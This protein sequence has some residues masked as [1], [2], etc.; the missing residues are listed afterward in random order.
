MIGPRLEV[1][2]VDQ[3]ENFGSTELSN[4][5][6]AHPPGLR[7]TTRY[8]PRS[9]GGRTDSQNFAGM[10]LLGLPIVIFLVCGICFSISQVMAMWSPG[11]A[12]RAHRISKVLAGLWLIPVA[13]TLVAGFLPTAE[14]AAVH[15][16]WIA[17]VWLAC[18]LGGML[19]V[20]M[21]AGGARREAEAAMVDGD[22]PGLTRSP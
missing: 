17:V 14:K 5:N 9:K 19:A 7:V 18:F 16:L 21:C 11:R 2:Q 22:N 1:W 3:L 13:L 12:R 4:L 10:F 8:F 15:P 20:R 6:G